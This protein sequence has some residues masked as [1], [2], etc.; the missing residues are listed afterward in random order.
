MGEELEINL[1]EG[2]SYSGARY[3][4]YTGKLGYRMLRYSYRGTAIQYWM[5]R[6]LRQMRRP[7]HITCLIGCAGMHFFDDVPRSRDTIVD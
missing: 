5:Q 3:Y 2:V 7:R 4:W 6:Y 1:F